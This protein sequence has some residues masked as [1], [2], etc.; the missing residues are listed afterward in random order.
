MSNAVVYPALSYA[1][2]KAAVQWLKDAFGFEELMVV[3]GD[4]DDVVH[5]ELA[6]DGAIIM[7]GS[8]KRD[9][10]W[11]SPQDLPAVSQTVYIGLDDPDAH[12]ARAKA[13]GAKITRE[14]NGTYRPAV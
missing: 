2:A 8:A 10:G 13:A 12:Y 14:P 9:M 6:L 1:D 5:A 7:L 3:P 4:G 11:V